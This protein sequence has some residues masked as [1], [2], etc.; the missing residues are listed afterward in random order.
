MSYQCL[1]AT[2]ANN[3][4]EIMCFPTFKEMGFL[5]SKLAQKNSYIPKIQ[6]E[7]NI[8]E[9]ILSYQSFLIQP[10]VPKYNVTQ[11]VNQSMF[12]DYF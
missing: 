2:K 7:I 4:D 3:Q 12:S 6:S 9:Y 1:S 8:L 10:V 5:P 11:V